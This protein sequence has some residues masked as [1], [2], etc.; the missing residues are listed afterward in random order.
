M[1]L[2]KT[3]MFLVTGLIL[4]LIIGIIASISYLKY[5][6]EYKQKS[7]I[8][9]YKKKL[10]GS[11]ICEYNCP[12]IEQNISGKIQL[13]P[14][15]SCVES[16]TKD[17]KALPNLYS[18]EQLNGDN[19]ILEVQNVITECKKQSTQNFI[20]NNTEF[21]PCNSREL[22]KLSDKFDYLK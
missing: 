14:D 8:N 20:L 4:G 17:F 16:C 15:S 22:S 2:K 5:Y 7:E 19:Y 10:I 11:I 12:I 9:S 21:F 13:I 6:P 3:S 18:N 1:K